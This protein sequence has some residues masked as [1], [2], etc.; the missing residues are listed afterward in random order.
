MKTNKKRK[1]LFMKILNN[2]GKLEILKILKKTMFVCTFQQNHYI[3]ITYL[4]DRFSVGATTN[5]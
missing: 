4:I 5:Y 2:K 1:V 3:G